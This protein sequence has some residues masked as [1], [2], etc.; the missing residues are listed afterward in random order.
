MFDEQYYPDESDYLAN[1]PQD[2]KCSK[3]K[4]YYGIVDS[5][6]SVPLGVE[7]Q[8]NYSFVFP[9][10][11]ETKDSHLG[12]YSCPYCGHPVIT[13]YALDEVVEGLLPRGYNWF[14]YS[15]LHN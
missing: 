6:S 5:E 2:K 13:Y 7:E 1:L 10:F 15:E 14:Y 8:S 4:K 12:H 9:I 11:T 3:C